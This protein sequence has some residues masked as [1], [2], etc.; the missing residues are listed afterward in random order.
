MYVDNVISGCDQ[1]TDIISYNQES[2]S[3]MNAANFNLRSWASNSPQ[4][5]ERAG[6]DQTADTSTVVNILG[7]RWH[8]A[9]DTLYLAPKEMVPPSSQPTSKR[10]VLQLASKTYDPLGFISP[11]TVKAKL[12]IQELWQRKLEWDEPLPTELETKWNDIA[13]DIQEASKL[14]L[15][16][17][18][19]S[20]VQSKAQP[21]YL[22]V[23]AN[24][25]PKAYGATAYISTCDQPSL[26]MSKSR[27]APMKKLTLPQLELMAASICTRLAHFIAEALKSRFPNLAIHLWSDSEIV[28]HWLQGSKPLK[29]F[30]ANRTK[31]I[32][33]LFPLSVW[34]HYPTHEN[35]ADLLTRGITATQLRTSSLWQHGP[36]WLP[37]VEQWP[38]W[39][40]SKVLHLHLCDIAEDTDATANNT[41]TTTDGTTQTD[42]AEKQPGIHNLIDVSRFST[43]SRLLTVTAYVLRFVKNLQNRTTKTDGP[44]SVQ[45]RQEALRKWIQN[46]QALIYAAE[47]A[48][49]RCNSNTRLTLV[50]QLRLFLDADGFLRCGGRIHNAQLAESAKFPYLL[51][52]NYPF[53]ALIVYETHRKQL[54]SGVNVVVTMLRQTFWITSIRQYVRKL[55]CRCVTC[56][57]VQGTAF[58]A[59]DPAPLPKL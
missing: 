14:V 26:V 43:L 1:E 53:T 22:H 48:N 50:K 59:P 20:Q 7:L 56:R 16:R 55:L 49:L 42:P 44:L 57:K 47:I 4:L 21:V 25:S 58:R 34:N 18:F 31:E 35:P 45:E 38:S 39:K 52:P 6:Q 9:Q 17:C 10:D 33:A 30:I 36:Q 24:A 8:P 23:F 3:I 28:L 13:R 15:P 32:K 19:F 54:H 2:R 37:H 12:F 51:P 27:V 5:R 29:Q 46:S 41:K 11:V 40:P